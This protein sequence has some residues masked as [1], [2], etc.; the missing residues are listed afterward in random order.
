[1]PDEPNVQI[2]MKQLCR[3]PAEQNKNVDNIDAA[4]EFDYIYLYLCVHKHGQ[5]KRDEAFEP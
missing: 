5:T 1:M 3:S 4:F 2:R